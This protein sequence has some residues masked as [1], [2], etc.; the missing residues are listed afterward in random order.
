MPSFPIHFF[1]S[2]FYPRLIFTLQLPSRR[3]QEGLLRVS[4]LAHVRQVRSSCVERSCTMGQVAPARPVKGWF[5][6]VF[7][8]KHVVLVPHPPPPKKKVGGWKHGSL[9]KMEPKYMENGCWILKHWGFVSFFSN[10]LHLKVAL[11]TKPIEW[12]S[13][14][15]IEPTIFVVFYDPLG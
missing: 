14:G 10:S 4:C 8:E 11:N 6:W 15:I 3:P 9:K 12:D 13:S 1:L 2:S 7:R 5:W